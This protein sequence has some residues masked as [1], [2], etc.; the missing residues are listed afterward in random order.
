M[1]L[2]KREVTAQGYEKQIGV[3]HLGHFVLTNL[4]LNKLRAS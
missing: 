2:P 3:N 1:A 4:L